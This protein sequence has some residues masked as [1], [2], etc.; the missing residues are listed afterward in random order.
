MFGTVDEARAPRTPCALCVRNDAR[1]PSTICCPVC[2]ELVEIVRI[3]RV[4]CLTYVELCR[5]GVLVG[6]VRD[7]AQSLADRP[8]PR[9][10]AQLLTENPGPGPVSTPE[11]L[12]GYVNDALTHRDRF[13]R[14][15]P[16]DTGERAALGSRD[17]SR[18]PR[19]DAADG[20]SADTVP[21]FP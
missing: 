16:P 2:T 21:W 3:V 14:G 12:R 1:G 13:R 8:V 6:A 9:D 20:A 5:L 4:R 10:F 17:R 7:C 15:P 18:S 19:R 11:V